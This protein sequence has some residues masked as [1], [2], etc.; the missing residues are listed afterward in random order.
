ME[1]IENA[2]A[3]LISELSAV[4]RLRVRRIYGRQMA[5]FLAGLGIGELAWDAEKVTV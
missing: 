1:Q 5:G 2:A 3:A 4:E